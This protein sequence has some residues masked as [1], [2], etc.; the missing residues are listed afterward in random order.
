MEGEYRINKLNTLM[1]RLVKEK[2]K[3][4]EYYS[5]EVKEKQEL[6]LAL[7]KEKNTL[8][9]ELQSLMKDVKKAKH[10]IKKHSHMH[11]PGASTKTTSHPKP[12]AFMHGGGGFI[13]S[14]IPQLTV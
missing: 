7:A 10:K 12:S 9:L 8:A 1:Q 4:E 13:N 11:L 14:S 6:V 3:L 5:Y 2:Q